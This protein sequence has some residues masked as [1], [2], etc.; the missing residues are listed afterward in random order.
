MQRRVGDE[1]ELFGI[2]AVIGVL[3]DSQIW[4]GVAAPSIGNRAKV[5]DVC[6]LGLE[7]HRAIRRD[8]FHSRE[9]CNGVATHAPG[10]QG[11]QRQRPSARQRQ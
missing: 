8:P 9:V 3:R 5:A 1:V 11:R 6:L 2:P 10:I 4:L 7:K